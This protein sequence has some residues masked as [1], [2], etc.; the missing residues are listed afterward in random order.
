MS[1]DWAAE[2]RPTFIGEA[3]SAVMTAVQKH[4]EERVADKAES[5]NTADKAGAEVGQLTFI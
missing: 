5:M 2:N 4:H 1:A 3:T